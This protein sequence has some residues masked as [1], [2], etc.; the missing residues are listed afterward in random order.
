MFIFKA[1]QLFM[2][3]T[4]MVFLAVF[5]AAHKLVAYVAQNGPVEGFARFLAL[6]WA[7]PHVAFPANV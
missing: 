4:R 3:S 1:R 7:V 2:F 5:V 6:L